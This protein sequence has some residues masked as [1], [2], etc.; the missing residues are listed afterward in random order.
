MSDISRRWF[1]DGKNVPPL[2]DHGGYGLIGGGVVRVHKCVL[3]TISA[4]P[5]VPNLVMDVDLLSFP[6][7]P[8]RMWH[9]GGAWRCPSRF[10]TDQVFPRVLQEGHPT[11]QHGRWRSATVAV[12]I[13]NGCC[14][15]W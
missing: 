10:G 11:R 1:C 13:V 14:T 2:G 15:V 12:G 3:R 7:L 6:S 9:L 8:G 5:A 4:H